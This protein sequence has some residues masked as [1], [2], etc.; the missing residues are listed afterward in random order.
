MLSQHGVS[1]SLTQ[2]ALA[3]ALVANASAVGI[4]QSGTVRRDVVARAL[5]GES[6]FRNIEVSVDDDGRVL[7]TGDLPVLWVKLRAIKA[8][9]EAAGGQ[10]IVSELRVP[11]AESDQALAE[12]VTEAIQRYAY[13]TVF[14]DIS[15]LVKDGAV[16]LS[17]RVT[18][19]PDKANDLTERV[20]RVLGVQDIQN[21]IETMTGSPSDDELRFRLARRIFGHPSFERF[22]NRPNP[23]FHVVVENGIVT[24]VGYV[25]SR[26]E[27]LELQEIVAFTSGI[28]RVDNQLETL[29]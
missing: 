29:R 23:P 19:V 24:L 8:A 4:A 6:D 25:Q 12:A 11:R 1:R 18:A 3:V 20:A 21:Q 5:A 15:G 16:T 9:L 28:L 10:E 2:V 7:L 17:G 22:G 27:M 14:D 26:T 13:Y